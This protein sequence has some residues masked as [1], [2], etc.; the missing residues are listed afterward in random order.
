MYLH[1]TCINEFM[2]CKIISINSLSV[3][4]PARFF[5]LF[6]GGGGGGLL[7]NG[8]TTSRWLKAQDFVNGFKQKKRS[9]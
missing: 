5:V 8:E 2:N 9:R 6:G 1:N 3:V 4:D 7:T